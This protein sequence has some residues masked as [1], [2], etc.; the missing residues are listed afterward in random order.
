[1]T[2]KRTPAGRWEKGGPGVAGAWGIAFRHREQQVQRP[3]F[4]NELGTFKTERM[5]G[6]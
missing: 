5:A 4:G 1:M 2:C 3:W 6:E